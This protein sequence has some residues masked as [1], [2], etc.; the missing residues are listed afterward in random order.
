MDRHRMNFPFVLFAVFVSVCVPVSAQELVQAAL[1]SSESNNGQALVGE[2]QLL[3]G[4]LAAAVSAVDEIFRAG[5]P[6]TAAR[7]YAK[8]SLRFGA[9]E[10]LMTR[11]FVAQVASG[12]FEQ[13]L[14]ICS[15]ARLMKVEI[16][17]KMLPGNSVSGLGISP[18]L[19]KLLSEELAALTILQSSDPDRLDVIA[20][21][22]EI[23]GEEKRSDLFF[24][25]AQQIRSAEILPD[26]PEPL[27]KTS[28]PAAPSQLAVPPAPA[29]RVVPGPAAGS[30]PVEKP[31]IS[32]FE[33]L[34]SDS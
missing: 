20:T 26:R 30:P 25:K 31:A 32:L 15:L 5:S 11:R 27:I 4:E 34:R 23:N 3:E 33:P 17:N 12:H 22:L 10:S 9:S 8:L 19:A 21:W 14:V 28:L 16:S 13:A 2:Q 24:E 1:D 29:P 18:P 6:R 7:H